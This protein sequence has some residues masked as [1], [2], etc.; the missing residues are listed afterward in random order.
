MNRFVT[1]LSAG[2]VAIMLSTSAYAADAVV[3]PEQIAAAKTPADHEAI[4]AAFDQEAARLEAKA[5]E[6]DA[7]S[8]SYRSA[9][10]G[11]KGMNA[12]AMSAHCLKLATKYREAA[13][14][15]RAMAAEH[16]K[17]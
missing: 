15:N 7:M 8:K 16:R 11:K 13:E 12:A 1:M 10:T 14:E 6:H 3:S 4:A 17:M 9:A 2:A 5:K